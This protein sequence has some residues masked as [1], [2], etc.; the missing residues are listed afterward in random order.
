MAFTAA[1]RWR[2]ASSAAPPPRS[3]PILFYFETCGSVAFAS[4]AATRWQRDCLR[5][6]GIGLGCRSGHRNWRCGCDGCSVRGFSSARNCE[7]NQCDGGEAT[8]PHSHKSELSS[9]LRLRGLRKSGSAGV[10]SIAMVPRWRII[11]NISRIRKISLSPWFE[12]LLPMG[13]LSY[14]MRLTSAKA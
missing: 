7:D 14:G 12:S 9:R 2:T 13:W 10:C 3:K 1:H 6:R 5:A 11:E 8:Q 4:T